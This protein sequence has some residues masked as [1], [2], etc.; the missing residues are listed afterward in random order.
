VREPGSQGF[1]SRQGG[2]R[3]SFWVRAR[4]EG[5][6]GAGAPFPQHSVGRR[7]SPH[8]GSHRSTAGCAGEIR[9]CR[10]RATPAWLDFLAASVSKAETKDLCFQV[11]HGASRT[12]TGDLLGAIQERS[13]A[14]AAPQAGFRAVRPLEPP[15]IPRAYPWEFGDGTRSIP[16]Y[17][18]DRRGPALPAWEIGR[19]LSA[20]RTTSVVRRARPADTLAFVAKAGTQLLGH[21]ARTQAHGR[22]RV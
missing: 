7:A 1:S 5:F 3:P 13:S 14:E 21:H 12:R 9:A 15:R 18:P 20:K 17:P 4:K 22:A 16:Q 6:V 2:R 11:F 10:L 19:E 8:R